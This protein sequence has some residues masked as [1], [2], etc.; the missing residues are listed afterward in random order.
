M[1]GYILLGILT[2]LNFCHLETIFLH[3]RSRSQGYLGR[4]ILTAA[5]I[6]FF[7]KSS[8]IMSWYH[9]ITLY[10][11]HVILTFIQ[12]K[13]IQERVEHL[14]LGTGWGKKPEASKCCLGRWSL[15]GTLMWRTGD[16]ARLQPRL[17]SEMEGASGKNFERLKMSRSVSQ[18]HFTCF[19]VLPGCGAQG[20]IET[21]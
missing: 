16:G 1:A 3:D 14:D 6:I 17:S 18:A 20:V 21:K 12:K 9:S 15:K 4:T 5:E 11:A 7:L 8:S 19:A 13:N 2:I 10:R